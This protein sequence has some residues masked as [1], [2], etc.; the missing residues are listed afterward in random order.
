[1]T[2]MAKTITIDTD[3]LAQALNNSNS[4]IS[5][6]LEDLIRKGLIFERDK[7][8]APTINECIEQLYTVYKEQ[9]EDTPVKQAQPETT[10]TVQTQEDLSEFDDD[11]DL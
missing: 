3:L 5:K 9:K 6:R 7:S 11:F 10:V 2:R 4:N 1:M 8:S